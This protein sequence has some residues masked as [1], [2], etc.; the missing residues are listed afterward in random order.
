MG[1]ITALGDTV[2]MA[3]ERA[4]AAKEAVKVVALGHA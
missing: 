2:E 4:T 1:H 3:R